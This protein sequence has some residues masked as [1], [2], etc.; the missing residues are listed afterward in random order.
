MQE[1]ETKSVELADIEVEDFIRFCQ[2]A[3]TGDYVPPEPR[4]EL[5]NTLAQDKPGHDSQV[6]LPRLLRDEADMDREQEVPVPTSNEIFD[7]VDDDQRSVRTKKKKRQEEEIWDWTGPKQKIEESKY[8]KLRKSFESRDY[9]GNKGRDALYTPYQPVANKR[10]EED[11]ASVFLGH[12]RLYT[13]GDKYGVDGLTS[14]ALKKLHKTLVLFR[15]YETRVGDILQLVRYT[16]KHTQGYSTDPL[17]VMVAEY[18]VGEIDTIGK[19]PE[20]YSLL[21]EG[22]EFVKDMWLLTRKH[23]L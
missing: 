10:S 16:Y 20:F 19:S 17:R 8:V 11:F 14:A 6:K 18:L 15:L 9:S 22:G 7:I 1:A 12:A 13:L 2:F 21:E 3:Y 23:L 5:S 4:V